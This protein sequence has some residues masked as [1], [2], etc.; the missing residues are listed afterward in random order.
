VLAAKTNAD[1]NY[2]L[3]LDKL[4]LLQDEALRKQKAIANSQNLLGSGVVSTGGNV[5]N[6]M[7]SALETS[8]VDLGAQFM[9]M[10]IVQRAY[11]ANARVIT[12]SDQL[13]NEVV[14]LKR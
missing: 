11:Q 3:Q 1:R 4:K 14:N 5:G 10:I 13:L 8:N 7:A 2:Q 6:I 9:K 12:T